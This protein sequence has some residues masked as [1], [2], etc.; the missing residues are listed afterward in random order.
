MGHLPFLAAVDEIGPREFE[1]EIGSRENRPLLE[2]RFPVGNREMWIYA[3]S[4]PRIN[5]VW[6]GPIPA[7]VALEKQIRRG[8]QMRTCSLQENSLH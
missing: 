1:H 7:Y 3:V 6:N 5:V 4:I 8:L 2:E